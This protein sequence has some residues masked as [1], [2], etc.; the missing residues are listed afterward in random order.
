VFYTDKYSNA[1]ANAN[2]N[3]NANTNANTNAVAN[4]FSNTDSCDCYS[5]A[6][7]GRCG[8]SY[9]C[10]S[11]NEQSPCSDSGSKWEGGSY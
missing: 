11:Y 1:V 5:N 10:R 6:D 8:G 9:P 4:T 3:A 2:A 7:A